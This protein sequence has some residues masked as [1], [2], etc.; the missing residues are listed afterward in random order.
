M[1]TTEIITAEREFAAGVE[2]PAAV[3]QQWAEH[4]FDAA[5]VRAWLDARCFC[6]DAAAELRDAGITPEQASTRTDTDTIGYRV[7]NGDLGL[8]EVREALAA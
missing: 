8:A 4:G 3:A 2:D 7:S 5:D 1:S 6:P